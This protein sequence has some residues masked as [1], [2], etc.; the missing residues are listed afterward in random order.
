MGKSL[1]NIALVFVTLVVMA[2]LFEFVIF[3]F[4]LRAADLPRLQADGSAVLKYQPNQT[5][6]YRLQSEIAARY[7]INQQGWNS[8]HFEYDIGRSP[9]VKRICIVGDSYVEAL[10]VDFD[11]S[12]AEKLQEEL[13][14]AGERIEVFRFGLSGAPLSQYVYWIKKE[15]VKFSPDLIVVNLVHNDFDQSINPPRGTY[16]KSFAIVEKFDD[17]LRL[18]E[19]IPYRRDLS[20]HIKNSA[21]FRYLWVREQ[22]RPDTVRDI[23]DRVIGLISPS[24]PIN[25]SQSP[26]GMNQQESRKTTALSEE[27][28]EAATSF[29]FDEISKIMRITNTKILLVMDGDRGRGLQMGQ[30]N[31]LNYMVKRLAQARSLSLLDLSTMF[32]ADHQ[33]YRKDHQFE[34]DGHWNARSHALVASSIKDFL[35]TNDALLT[36]RND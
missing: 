6:T 11:K 14:D 19:P 21:I 36:H 17:E 24:A 2:V 13:L 32:Q 15:V 20:W 30:S 18:T 33:Q 7:R 9:G 25:E 10:Q 5:G 35:I 29:L 12:F 34:T 27:E 16:S 23:L 22:I 4:V 28:I 31:P 26:A 8:G 1:K 3:R